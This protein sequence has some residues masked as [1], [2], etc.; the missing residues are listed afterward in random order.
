MSPALPSA[1]KGRV[2]WVATADARG[3]V[4]R[5]QLLARALRREQVEVDV[6]TTSDEG[7]AFLSEFG[8]QADVLSRDYRVEFDERHNMD[9]RRTD[10][11]IARYVLDPTRMLR[12]LRW[13]ARRASG[14][15]LVIDDSNH[16][17][18][19]F[20]PLLKWAGDVRVVHV[21]GRHLRLALETNF[22]G[23]APRW[24]SRFYS[25]VI[26]RLMARGFARIEHTFDALDLDE[27]QGWGNFFLPPVVGVPSRTAAE[28]RRS[29]GVTPLERL[30]VV[31]LNPHF[32]DSTLAAKL[33]QA[34]AAAG[35]RM[36]AIGEGYPDRPG[37][38]ARDP[39]LADAIGAADLFV[40]GIGM[41]ALAQA[42]AFGVP[43]LGVVGEQPEQMQNLR[44][45]RDAGHAFEVV[46]C[47]EAGAS[48]DE[49][50]AAAIQRLMHPP[51]AALARPNSDEAIVKTQS[52]WVNLL[53]Q[54]IERA[55]RERT[56]PP[57]RIEETK[58]WRAA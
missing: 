47:E 39:R 16:P 5:A 27:R 37:W 19:L 21:Y 44:Y 13:F 14:M 1:S 15:D 12:D 18:L 4:M 36:H 55:R 41:A 25:A 17:A 57:A 42:R 32:Q 7:A 3:H 30:A 29:L 34:L 24:F 2:L 54:L 40:S 35:F 51:G 56:L 28:A 50:L 23:R 6:V 52:L 48:L 9:R 38:R 8:I 33:E 58:E 10:A 53:V 49:R 46:R 20:L 22:D 45:L 26:R 11:T 43:F 31:Y